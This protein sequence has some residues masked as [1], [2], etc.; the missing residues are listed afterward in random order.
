MKLRI[1]AEYDKLA[2]IYHFWSESDTAANPCL[3]FYLMVCKQSKGPIVEF[4][5]GDGRIA[6]EIAKTGV[7]VIG[8]DIS[9]SMLLKCQ[10]KATTL[11]VDDLIDLKFGDIRNISMAEKVPIVI[12]PFRT[13]GHLI[14]RSDKLD[15]FQNAFSML[16]TNGIFVFDHY[17]FDKEWAW[18]HDNK[19]LLMGE[20]Y[21]N[22][23]KITTR[24]W[25]IYNYDYEKQLINCNIIIERID[26]DGVV[27]NRGKNPLTFSWILPEEIR[28]LAKST[29]FSVDH[30]YG[31]F[32]F[33]PFTSES[34]DQVW[35][36]RKKG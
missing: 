3:K 4:G 30:L 23:T 18:E 8:I 34:K 27:L 10:E 17:I 24:V 22:K 36:L 25:D 31:D 35:I 1:N 19:P 32:S 14:E 33:G 28:D 5:I 16:T 21:D 29:G 20:H 7:R 9:N 26:E 15:T 11:G 2:D 6:I 13:I 12:L